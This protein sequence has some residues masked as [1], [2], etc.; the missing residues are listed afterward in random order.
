MQ[1]FVIIIT[2]DPALPTQADAP[3]T[4]STQPLAAP[5]TFDMHSPP[6]KRTI[7]TLL[8]EQR[9]IAPAAVEG[10]DVAASV[11]QYAAVYEL[12]YALVAAFQ[13]RG[14][15][16]FLGY[17]SHLGARRH[18]GERRAGSPPPSRVVARRR[19]SDVRRASS[20]PSY[21]SGKRTSTS[22]FSPRTKP[23]CGPS[24]PTLCATAQSGR[25]SPSST[26]TSA[27]SCW[28]RG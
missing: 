24:S 10:S 5:R 21:R 3:P 26:T 28:T 2:I 16:V 6:S 17:G 25:A 27:F 15:P 14:I 8:A 20:Q 11:E 9:R 18:H 23:G 22:R 19:A 12:T 1:H 7:A 13:R 4:I